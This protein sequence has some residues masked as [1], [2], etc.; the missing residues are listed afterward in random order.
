[1]SESTLEYQSPSTT[2]PP[3]LRRVWI[4]GG[5]SAALILAVN[6]G[7]VSMA[8]S[9]RSW[10]ALGI[11]IMVG[12]ITNGVMLIVS[13][14]FTPVVKRVSYGARGATIMPYVMIGILLPIALIFV[15]GAIIGSMDL[16]GC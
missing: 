16:H 9:D 8:A 1:M 4:T 5:I 10:G 15:D 7:L 3:S 14:L 13:L 11:M 2:R 6:T 12:P